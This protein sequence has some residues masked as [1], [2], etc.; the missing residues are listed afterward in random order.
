M[1]ENKLKIWTIFFNNP[2]ATEEIPALRG[3]VIANVGLENSL[4][5][6]HDADD[7]LNY[8]YPLIQYKR[9]H[10]KAAIVCVGEGVEAFGTFFANCCFDIRLGQRDVTLQVEQTNAYQH[11]VQLWDT[12][13]TYHIRKWLPLNQENYEKY[14]ALESMAD[15]FAML[16]RLLT[17]NILSFAKGVGIHFEKQVECKITEI[18]EPRLITFKGVKMMAFDAEFKCNVS[19]PD[20]VG[21]GKGVSLGYGTVKC[22]DN[23][24]NNINI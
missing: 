12:M 19:L 3:A 13:F 23:N 18:D 10:Q 22:L 8:R 9:I 11:L 16:E 2:I 20:Y 24:D 1:R 17:G 21:L 14:M 6:N 7:K 5:H 15:K 4:F